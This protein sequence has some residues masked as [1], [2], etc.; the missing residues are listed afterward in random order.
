LRI[1]KIGGKKLFFTFSLPRASRLPLGKEICAECFFFAESFL[2]TLG[3]EASL[4]NV[5]SLPRVFIWLSAKPSLPGVFYLA[6]DKEP[7]SRQS[8]RFRTERAEDT[9]MVERRKRASTAPSRL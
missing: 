6:L 1:E 2:I 4:P 7:S 9:K 3:K 5:V 8:L